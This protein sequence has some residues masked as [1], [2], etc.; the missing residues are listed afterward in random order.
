MEDD[1]LTEREI[2]R[3]FGDLFQQIELRTFGHFDPSMLINY[4]CYGFYFSERPQVSEFIRAEFV[5][6]KYQSSF[7]N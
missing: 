7:V 6:T 1:K 2:S 4:G 5:M 3:S